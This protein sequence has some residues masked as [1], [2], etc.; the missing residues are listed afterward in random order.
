MVRLRCIRALELGEHIPESATKLVRARSM[1]KHA[2]TDQAPEGS[3][4]TSG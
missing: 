1:E 3:V 4:C 2:M